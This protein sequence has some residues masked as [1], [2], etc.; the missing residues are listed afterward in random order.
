MP[1]LIIG[2]T[3][4]IVIIITIIVINPFVMVQSQQIGIITSF[5]AIKGTMGEGLQI[6]NPFTTD[7]V[8]MDIRMPLL[9]GYS[10][11]RIIK[12]SLPDCRN[13]PNWNR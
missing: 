11:T 9:D 12:E 5:G 6:I 8:L 1:K 7:V 2:V 4:L 13:S 3:G 10:A